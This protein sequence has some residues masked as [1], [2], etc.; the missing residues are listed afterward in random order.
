M[1]PLISSCLVYFVGF[2]SQSAFANVA[3]RLLKAFSIYNV[4]EV[5]LEQIKINTSYWRQFEGFPQ[6]HVI[7]KL[8]SAFYSYF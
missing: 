1:I 6:E 8:I 2:L 3:G 5:I 4:T 7:F